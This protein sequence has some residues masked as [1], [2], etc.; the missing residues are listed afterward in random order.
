MGKGKAKNSS[1]R[2][3]E[4]DITKNFSNHLSKLKIENK[5]MKILEK[6][7]ICR[8]S[9]IDIDKEKKKHCF[10][11]F[12]NSPSQAAF[13]E[14]HQFLLKKFEENFT[15]PVVLIPERNRI[16]GNLFRKYQGTKVPRDRTLDSIFNAYLEDLVY[17]ATIVGKRIRFPQGKARQFKVIID[18]VDKDII[19]YKVPSIVVCYKALTNRALH[20]EFAESKK[21]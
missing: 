14:V 15:T 10:L 16:N 19:D 17:P 8:A 9:E 12:L 11:V 21:I 1:S 6:I 3:N 2:Q 5:D 4:T 18:P 20:V 13:K 7:S